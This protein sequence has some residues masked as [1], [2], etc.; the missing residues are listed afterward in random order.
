MVP[1][2]LGRHWCG[3]GAGGALA[4]AAGGWGTVGVAKGGGGV[5]QAGPRGR[6][7]V[8]RSWGVCRRGTGRCFPWSLGAVDPWLLARLRE[9]EQA[10]HLVCPESQSQ[11]QE[12]DSVQLVLFAVGPHQP[13]VSLH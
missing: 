11:V 8:G 5:I 2:G 7:V 1:E 3:G 12:H 13:L 9:K 6:G 10:G 4:A